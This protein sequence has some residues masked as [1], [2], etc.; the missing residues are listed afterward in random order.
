MAA[1]KAALGAALHGNR[2]AEF[3]ALSAVAHEKNGDF[4]AALETWDKCLCAF[5]Q[6][7]DYMEAALKLAWSLAEMRDAVEYAKKWLSLL[8]G[9]FISH[10][11]FAL[12]RGLENRGCPVPGVCGIHDGF[13]RAWLWLKNGERPIIRAN[14][15]A[16]KLRPQ[17]LTAATDGKHA[18]HILS[19]PLP[20]HN[21][22][23]FL[24]I[25]NS[26]GSH[27]RGSPLLCSSHAHAVPVKKSA[28][29]GKITIIMPVYDDREATLSAL[30]S[31]FASR[32]ANSK[33]FNIL[34]IWDHGPNPRLLAD[35][36]RLAAEKRIGLLETPANYGFLG[37]VNFALANVTDGDV[38]LLNSDT[39]TH[40]D[41]IDRMAGIAKIPDAAT[42][43]PLG[44]QAEHMSFPSWH[45]RG[46]VCDLKTT[47]L[48][49]NACGKLDPDKAARA[50]PVGV[51]FCMLVTRRALRAVG[52]LDGFTLCKGY[53]EESDFSLRAKK[54]GLVN[55]G[56]FNVFVAHLQGRSFGASKTAL[57][58]QNNVAIKK[59]FHYYERAF[60]RFLQDDSLRQLRESIS[61][62]LCQ[63][64]EEMPLE[65]MPWHMGCS[66]FWDCE[67]YIHAEKPRAALFVLAAGKSPVR[68]A[69]K[70]RG[71]LPLHDMNFNLPSGM[72]KL[73]QAL[74]V[75]ANATIYNL[76]DS[77]LDLA[78][79]L[80]PVA[81]V[82][83]KE[84]KAD[85]TLHKKGSL[86]SSCYF[87]A[88]PH[89][90]DDALALR[91]LTV[92]NSDVFIY[93]Y[94]LKK[95]LRNF[96]MPPNLLEMPEMDNAAHLN[97]GGLILYPETDYDSWRIWLDRQKLANLP[98]LCLERD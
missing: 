50:I 68:A 18:L 30:G 31:V 39:L 26:G 71:H 54:E 74:D 12:L 70:I 20:E 92:N 27:L 90:L 72:E 41:W 7:T 9:V 34:V 86:P 93:V 60:D 21:A 33:A 61:I 77:P 16:E 19:I 32:K 57:A 79:E 22:P 96:P 11:S 81:R 46:D 66:P 6:K 40:G 55:Y 67:K 73:R 65:I 2:H 48:I 53:G 89:N 29:D 97:P 95:Y 43:T 58:A 13:V 10:P 82:M 5:P 38:I 8:E 91:Q 17:L 23:Y 76:K 63:S 80:F 44:S 37:A 15:P 28:H 51:G 98:V 75:F 36:R 87:A 94:R 45:S 25:T 42:V 24:A 4:Q 69:L 52:G 64:I 59:R 1:S 56:A 78:R 3:Y 62:N 47:A 49:D 84:R 88:A 85:A 14:L 83:R 35:L